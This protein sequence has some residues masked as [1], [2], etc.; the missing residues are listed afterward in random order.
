MNDLNPCCK[1]GCRSSEG[2]IHPNCECHDVPVVVIQEK[3]HCETC[4][5][6]ER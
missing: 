2:C 5:C 6:K 1:G 3:P 4:R